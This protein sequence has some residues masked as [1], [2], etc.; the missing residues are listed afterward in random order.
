MK[1]YYKNILNNYILECKGGADRHEIRGEFG[2]SY[3]YHL[4]YISVYKIENL[5]VNNGYYYINGYPHK[6]ENQDAEAYEIK[7][8]FIQGGE[9]TAEILGKNFLNNS[10]DT[11]FR[12][13]RAY[14]AECD[15]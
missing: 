13:I 6:L 4:D 14:F 5:G 11:Q 8:Y 1:K 2:Y 9:H 7:E 10:I 12:K 15:F 3:N